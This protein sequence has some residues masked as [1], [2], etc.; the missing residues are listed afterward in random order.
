MTENPDKGL[1]ADNPLPL[2]DAED[3]VLDVDH[4]DYD[5]EAD[6]DSGGPDEELTGP[7]PLE[8]E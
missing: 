7:N 5:G 8:G 1:Q 6:S 3:I 2:E 4:P